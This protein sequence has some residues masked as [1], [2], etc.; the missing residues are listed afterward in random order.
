MHNNLYYYYESFEQDLLGNIDTKTEITLQTVINKDITKTVE[1]VDSYDNKGNISSTKNVNVGRYYTENKIA[2]SLNGIQMYIPNPKIKIKF[3][4]VNLW[5]GFRNINKQGDVSLFTE[6]LKTNLCSGDNEQYEYL[7]KYLAHMI[8]KPYERPGV[9]VVMPSE[10]GVGKDSFMQVIKAFVYNTNYAMITNTDDLTGFNSQV[11]GRL[12]V[13]ANEAIFSYK[14]EEAGRIK[15]FITEGQVNIERK[16]IDKYP[17]NNYARLFIASN[18]EKSSAL[19]E[20]HDRRYFVCDTQQ[21]LNKD[22]FDKFYHEL[23]YNNLAGSVLDWLSKLDIEDFDVKTY[24]KT[25]TA[26][27]I[28]EDKICPALQ[29]LKGIAL[30]VYDIEFKYDKIAKNHYLNIK[31]SDLYERVNQFY[32]HELGRE[33]RTTQTAFSTKLKSEYLFEHIKK[34]D[35]N[36]FNISLDRFCD[37]LDSHTKSIHSSEQIRKHFSSGF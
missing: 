25:L 28:Q 11:E 24:P 30:G 35:G 17:V 7:I 37:V 6:L 21:K 31:A 10:Q 26:C 36:Y 33:Y 1:V 14:L 27:R 8:Q 32:K 15:T 4:K 19:I 29:Y 12:I 3:N 20:P 23:Q 2:R 5:K 18:D 16:G 34:T 22:F 13:F 9:A